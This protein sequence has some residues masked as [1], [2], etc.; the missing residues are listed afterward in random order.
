MFV[1]VISAGLR[2]VDAFPVDV[3]VDLS[4]GMPY[5]ALVGLPEAAV[6]ESR[7]RIQSAM[8][9]SGLFFPLRRLRINLAPADIKKEGTAL[10]LPIAIG[11]LAAAGN[12]P[13]ETLGRFLVLGELSL[14]GKL[15]GVKGAL[16]SAVLARDMSLSGIVVP[17]D[18]GPEAAVVEGIDVYALDDLSQAV[19]FFRGISFSPCRLDRQKAFADYSF[20]DV[21]FGE[22]KGQEHAK[23]ALEVAAAGAHNVLMIGPPGS[24]KTMLA[25]RV[26][27]ILPIMSL[28]ES[29]ETTRVHSVAGLIEPG[30][31]LVATRPFRAPHHT[32][33]DVGLIGGGSYPRPGEVSLAHNGVLFLDELP[34]FTRGALEVLRQPMED[35]YVIITRA[36]AS[37]RFPARFTLIAAMNPCPC[38]YYTDPRHNCTCSAHQIKT[39]T[40]RISGPL[41]DRIDIH[42]EVPALSYD[43]LK[44]KREGEPSERIRERVMLAREQQAAR[45]TGERGVYFNSHMTARHIKRFCVIDE[46]SDALLRAAIER[47]GLSARAYS[48]VL[49]VARTIADLEGSD[50]IMA[51]HISEAIQYRVLDRTTW[52]KYG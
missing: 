1:K 38:G 24:G 19:E 2:G 39:Y 52:G 50:N 44:S 45:F 13:A 48:R 37:V 32:I 14:D 6:K 28:E 18:N 3:E 11:I 30:Q 9:N 34:E 27:T 36:K 15:R 8:A 47:F 4:Q 26:P 5:F 42:I 23:R 40:G 43:E 31:A 46:A 33:S 7:E 20:Y 22:V 41:L 49:K 35:G 12:I 25:R 21:D 51:H 10:D 16:P 29:L 17:A